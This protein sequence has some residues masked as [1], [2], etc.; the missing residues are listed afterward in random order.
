MIDAA[1]E[2]STAPLTQAGDELNCCHV[3]DTG[4]H[5]CFYY[6]PHSNATH[7]QQVSAGS[8]NANWTSSAASGTHALCTITRTWEMMAACRRWHCVRVSGGAHRHGVRHVRRLTAS[9]FLAAA[10]VRTRSAL[11]PHRVAARAARQQH[12]AGALRRPRHR[13]AATGE[14]APRR[15]GRSTTGEC[16]QV[17]VSSYVPR[18]LLGGALQAPSSL[19]LHIELLLKYIA[20]FSAALG[21]LNAV[22]CRALDGQHLAAVGRAS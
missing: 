6:A 2:H 19:P 22:P 21:L 11:Q 5:L 14:R 12:A 1:R 15:G 8:K 10:D 17:S 13:R 20:A 18:S 7:L 16:A 3:N 9:V 4:T